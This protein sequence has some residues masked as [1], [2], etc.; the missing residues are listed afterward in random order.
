[1]K[2]FTVYDEQQKVFAKPMFFHQRGEAIRAVQDE[3]RNKESMLANHPE[4]Y[5][6]YYLG[7][8]DNLTGIITGLEIPE[9]VCPVSDLVVTK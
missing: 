1:M 7:E 8:F 5:R 3:V 6:L 2:M 9:L 4:D